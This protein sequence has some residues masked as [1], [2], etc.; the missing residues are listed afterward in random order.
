M[1]RNVRLA[2]LNL[3]EDLRVDLWVSGSETVIPELSGFF[4]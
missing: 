1:L 2:A 3:E 4:A